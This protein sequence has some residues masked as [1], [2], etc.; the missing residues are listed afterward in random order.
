MV[1]NSSLASRETAV[2]SA[3]TPTT[4]ITPEGIDALRNY[5]AKCAWPRNKRMPK[6]NTDGM[7]DRIIAHYNLKRT[8]ASRQLRAWKLTKYDNAQVKI[9]MDPEDIET[10]IM[11]GISVELEEYVAEYFATVYEGREVPGCADATNYIQSINTL[12]KADAKRWLVKFIHDNPTLE[13]T[14]IFV[15]LIKRWNSLAA[16][17]FPQCAKNMSDSE[18]NFSVAVKEVQIIYLNQKWKSM[19]STIHL[20]PSTG[21][22]LENQW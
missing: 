1:L 9:I 15:D 4:K 17:A 14:T 10:S 22:W 8:Q 6:V 18:L 2:P 7:L 20:P 19:Y 12:H 21:H 5:F 11:E 13:F 16:E 3:A